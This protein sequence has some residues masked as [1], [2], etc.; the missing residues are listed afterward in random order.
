M[1]HSNTIAFPQSRSFSL[2]IKPLH[3]IRDF[4]ILISAAWEEAKALEQKSYKNSA[5]W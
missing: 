4:F 1:T 2:S 5:N 3:A